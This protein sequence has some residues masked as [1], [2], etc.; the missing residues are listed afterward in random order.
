MPDSTKQT[1]LIRRVPEA[2]GS[3]YELW[4]EIIPC[5]IPKDTVCLRFSTIWSGARDPQAPQ[6]KGEYFLDSAARHALSA[7]LS[8]VT[9]A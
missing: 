7:L 1:A 4:A 9:K 5:T 2:H 3:N 8:E 6:V